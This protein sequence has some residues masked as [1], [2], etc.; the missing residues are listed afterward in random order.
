MCRYQGQEGAHVPLPGA[1]GC[2]C[3]SYMSG[4][5]TDTHALGK[6]LKPRRSCVDD[7]S[8]HTTTQHATAQHNT[9]QHSTKPTA[10]QAKGSRQSLSP[11]HYPHPP[12]HLRPTPTS[13]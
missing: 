1:G 11:M 6:P 3:A 12:P 9:P 7:H 4:S 13:P 10:Q 8:Q 2:T 5:H